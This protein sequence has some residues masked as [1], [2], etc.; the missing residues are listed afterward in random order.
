MKVP[1]HWAIKFPLIVAITLTVLFVSYHYLVRPTFIGA[2]L[3]GR[4]Y[5][6]GS[7]AVEPPATG[8]GTAPAGVAMLAV[9]VAGVVTAVSPGR[10]EAQQQDPFGGL[11]QESCGVCHG[12]NLEG[13]AQGTPLAGADLRHG[14]SIAELTKSIA[15]GFP[16]TGM[17]AWSATLDATKIQRLAIF[18]AEKRSQLAYTDFKIAA[19]PA[20]SP[21]RRSNRA[22]RVS[23]RDRRGRPRSVALLDR[24]AAGRPDSAHREDARLEH[25]L[26]GRRAIRADS[27]HAG[28]VST[29]ASSARH[30]ARLRPRLLA[31]RRPAPR[32]RGERLDLPALTPTGAPTATPRAAHRSA[33]CR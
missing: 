10:T 8:A 12:A 1:L 5:P 30:P 16:A 25:H 28:S 9:L 27:R 23:R 13:A 32:L 6:R 18:I 20:A 11:Y 4:K 26:A 33:R 7:R 24:T 15:D 22:A 14:A 19:P 21:R 3:N 31:G 17:P 29:T 2:L